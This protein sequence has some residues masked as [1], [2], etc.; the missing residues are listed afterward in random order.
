MK[1]RVTDENE[2][3]QGVVKVP[4]IGLIA[5]MNLIIKAWRENDL[6]RVQNR[7]TEI[8]MFTHSQGQAIGWTPTSA[9]HDYCP[10][11]EEVTQL[12]SILP[13]SVRPLKKKKVGRKDFHV[14]ATKMLS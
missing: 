4:K 7:F 12:E 13:P 5:C 3:V 10:T 6:S 8:R 2:V 14:S 9:F 11:E 1:K